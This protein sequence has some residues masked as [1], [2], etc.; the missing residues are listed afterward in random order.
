MKIRRATC[1]FCGQD[2]EAVVTAHSQVIQHG[3]SVLA[4]LRS[5]AEEE[6]SQTGSLDCVV[7]SP[8]SLGGIEKQD[9]WEMTLRHMEKKLCTL[10]IVEGE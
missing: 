3:Q 4:F 1:Q 10:C 9:R 8:R 6:F 5:A 2:R 7:I